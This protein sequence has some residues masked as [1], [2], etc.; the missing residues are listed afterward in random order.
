MTRRHLT[1]LLAAS[2]ACGGS[3]TAE[4]TAATD[5]S[6]SGSTEPVSVSESEPTIPEAARVPLAEVELLEAGE[7]EK[8]TLRLRAEVGQTERMRMEQVMTMQIQ[9]GSQQVPEVQMPPIRMDFELRTTHVGDDG[10]MRHASRIVG[11]EILG[12]G[13][14]VPRLEQELAPLRDLSG[15]DVVDPRGRLVASQYDLPASASPE[16]RN[17][18]QRMQDAMRQIMPPLPEEPV[19][20]GA[21]WRAVSD[22]RSQIAFRQ[23]STYTLEALEG[24]R[25]VLSVQTEQSAEPQPMASDQPGVTAEL[26][27]FDGDASAR[28]ELALDHMVPRSEG[29]VRVELTTRATPQNGAPQEVTMKMATAVKASPL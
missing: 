20:V 9:I 14:L 11:L 22:V 26:L 8:R 6:H 7:G 28:I 18:L 19:A 24:D 15:W 17:S 13:P 12:E 4:T 25:M 21:R 23:V 5:P 16:L 2:L 29:D 10:A 3:S 27:A 1:L